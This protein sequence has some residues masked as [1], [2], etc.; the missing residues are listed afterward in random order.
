MKQVQVAN[1]NV[2]SMS[3]EDEGGSEYRGKSV[4]SLRRLSP[5]LA[6]FTRDDEQ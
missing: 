4:R 2:K 1:T 5:G 3:L 6:S